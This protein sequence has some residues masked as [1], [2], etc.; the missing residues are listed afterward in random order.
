MMLRFVCA[1]AL[2]LLA[3]PKGHSQNL[4]QRTLDDPHFRWRSVENPQAR[5]Y[6]KTGSFAERHRHQLLRSVTTAIAEDL[7]FLGESVYDDML[8]TS[9][10]VNLPATLGLSFDKMEPMWK[11]YLEREVGDGVQVDMGQINE[12]GCG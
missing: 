5:V 4:V 9:G 1:F 11:E 3:S 7:E 2:I 8:W 12:S 6:Y 10:S